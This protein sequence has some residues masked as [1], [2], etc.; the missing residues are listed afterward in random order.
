MYVWI[1]YLA[2]LYELLS[3]YLLKSSCGDVVLVMKSLLCYVLLPWC[4][5]RLL[6]AW[7]TVTAGLRFFSVHLV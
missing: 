7:D 4:M 5:P 3:L 6:G 2:I 1:C